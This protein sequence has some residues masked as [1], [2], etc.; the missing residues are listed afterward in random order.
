MGQTVIDMVPRV[1]L[2]YYIM[3]FIARLVTILFPFSVLRHLR[4][5]FFGQN[6]IS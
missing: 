6:T 1:S 3:L 5:F 2:G 4:S